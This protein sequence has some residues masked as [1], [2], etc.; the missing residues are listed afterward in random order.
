MTR[1]T[2]ACGAVDAADLAGEFP[3]FVGSE[4]DEA[5]GTGQEQRAVGEESHGFAGGERQSVF[6]EGF[7]GGQ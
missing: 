7:A 6:E 3:G 4:P 2:D 5:M 1:S